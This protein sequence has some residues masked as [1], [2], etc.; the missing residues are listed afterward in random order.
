MNN[1]L[2]MIMQ[3]T[4]T[5]KELDESLQNA[6]QQLRALAVNLNALIVLYGERGTHKA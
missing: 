5:L 4:S 1:E 2:E 3:A 6:M